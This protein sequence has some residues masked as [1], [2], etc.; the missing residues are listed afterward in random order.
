MI[1]DAVF[2]TGVWIKE[3]Q[4][5]NK[6]AKPQKGTRGDLIKKIKR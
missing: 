5:S 1:L 4:V 3:R 6:L 2:E